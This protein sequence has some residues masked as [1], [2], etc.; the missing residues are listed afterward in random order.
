MSFWAAFIFANAEGPKNKFKWIITGIAFICILNITRIILIA[1]ATHLHWK[2]I[3]SLDHHQTF[4]ILSYGCIFILMYLYINAQKKYNRAKRKY[5]QQDNKLSTIWYPK[6]ES[7]VLKQV[8]GEQLFYIFYFIR[9]G[10]VET[11]FVVWKLKWFEAR[12]KLK[13]TIFSDVHRRL[14]KIFSKNRKNHKNFFSSPNT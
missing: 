5:R 1:L 14:V 8:R 7:F 6:L 9:K 13:D 12:K 10:S 11:G 2:T 4:N 3:T